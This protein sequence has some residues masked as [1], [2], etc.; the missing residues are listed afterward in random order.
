MLSI[1]M[2]I[3]KT[4]P[5]A[6]PAVRLHPAGGPQQ[7]AA[8]LATTAAIPDIHGHSVALHRVVSHLNNRPVERIFLGD[9]FDRGYG[10]RAVYDI[11]RGEKRLLMGNHAILQLLAVKGDVWGLNKWLGNGAQPFLE[12]CG[13]NYK[14]VREA[15]EQLRR[16]YTLIGNN[17]ED[18]F[19]Q[20]Q[21]DYRAVLEKL[22]SEI[23]A[24]PVL[25]EIC[26]WLL[27]CTK[28]YHIDSNG[29]LYIHGG[30]PETEIQ[31]GLFERL[32]AI[33]RQFRDLLSTPSPDLFRLRQLRTILLNFLGV[34][35][36]E[37]LAPIAKRGE[38]AVSGY[39]RQMGVS[40]M[41]CAHTIKSKVEVT[42][43]RVFEIDLGMSA[44]NQGSFVTLGPD[45][46]KSFRETGPA[47]FTEQV[48]VTPAEWLI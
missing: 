23:M 42:G 22:S 33:H 43:G 4:T 17:M 19:V 14:P 46:V 11:L 28:L 16:R 3:R 15:E 48:L 44:F 25:R 35:G 10:N 39:L 27:E 21:V 40:G 41:V 9:F 45:G 24:N 2:S 1:K 13:I 8:V 12:E 5:P 18:L 37:F 32:D 26:S 29:I 36:D 34:R 7:R 38:N 20:M 31:P 30:V 47:G 6:M